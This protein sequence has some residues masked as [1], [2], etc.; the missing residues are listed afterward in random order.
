MIDPVFIFRGGVMETV[1]E[2]KQAGKNEMQTMMEAYEKLATPGE[3]H[4][5]L[6]KMEGVWITKSKMWMDPSMPPEESTGTTDNK[7]LYSGRFLHM[8]YTDSMRGTPVAGMV[9]M[10][11]DN[12]TKKYI[13]ASLGSMGTGIFMFEGPE[14]A[15][16][17]TI[18]QE[19]HYNEPV[20]GPMTYRAVTKIVDENT[21]TFEMTGMDKSGKEMKMMETTYIRKK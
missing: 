8:E 11:Y 16:G 21:Y 12:H 19:N 10:G 20:M 7:M 4:K 18:I 3:P 2:K 9:I 15:D 13:T 17:M 6:A 1:K 14:S 5:L